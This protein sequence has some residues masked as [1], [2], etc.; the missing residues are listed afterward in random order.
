MSFIFLLL[1][2]VGLTQ[3]AGYSN[4]NALLQK[5]KESCSGALS[6]RYDDDILI[7]DWTTNSTSRV[8]LVFNEHARERVTGELALRVIQSLKE[9][10]P[11]VSVTIIPVLNVWGRQRVEAGS[12]C[13][14]KNQRRV[15]TN[16][17]FWTKKHHY[18]K[19]SEEYE[20]S[21]PISEK[22]SKLIARELVNTTRYVNVHSG[23]FSLY[24]PYD[25][26]S[27]EPPNAKHMRSQLQKWSKHCPQCAVGS[28]ATVSNYK[29]YGTSSDWAIGMGVSESYTFEIY[30]SNSRHCNEMFNPPPDWLTSTLDPWL[31]IMKDVCT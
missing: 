12:E 28:A 19:G 10:S 18:S 26:S 5:A 11:P 30:G 7:V 23:E 22:E 1:F 8:L 20:G 3:I 14:R 16:R 9:W 24:M 17:N 13:Q 29:A 6:Y 2:S 21:S 25:A 4:T 27:Q 15:D 31:F